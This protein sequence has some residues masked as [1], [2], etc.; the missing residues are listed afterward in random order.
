MAIGYTPTCTDIKRSTDEARKQ[1]KLWQAERACFS[2]HF[3][4]AHDHIVEPLDPRFCRAVTL[5]ELRVH[6]DVDP[7]VVLL[8]H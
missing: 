7:R 6:E 8:V 3:P 5:R 2:H 1:A 4:D